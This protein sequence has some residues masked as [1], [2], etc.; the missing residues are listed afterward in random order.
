M[1]KQESVISAI[2]EKVLEK[3]P[4]MKGR[5]SPPDQ[6]TDLLFSSSYHHVDNENS[7]ANCDKARLVDRQ[8]RGTPGTLYPLWVDCIGRPVYERF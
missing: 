1:T 7:C 3:N 6:Q 5:F 4:D 8:P 2:I